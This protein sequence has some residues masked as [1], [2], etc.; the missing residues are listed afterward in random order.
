MPDRPKL[1][2]HSNS[3]WASTGYGNQTSLFAPLLN[4]HY[5]VAISAFYGLAGARL[6]WNDIP[7]LPGMEP[8]YGNEW[9]VEHARHWFDDKN[10][11]GGL[12][13]TLMD[14]W[15]LQADMA[16]QLNMACW[17]P[18]D[19]EP[20][21]PPVV[22]FFVESGAIPIAMSRFG[23]RMLGRLDPLYVPHGIDTAVLRP[24]P[25][26]ETREELGEG[27]AG[28]VFLIGMVAANKGRPSRKGFQ[29]A[30]Q[31]FREF[32]GRHDDARL[33]LHTV[34]TPLHGQGEDLAALIQAL[35]LPQHAVIFTDQYAAMLNP[36]PLPVMAKIYSAMDVL[37]NPAF[38]EGFGIP[39]L[40][41]QACGVP[42]VVTNF[43]AMQ[44]TCGAGWKVGCRPQWTGQNSWMAQPDVGE[45]VEALEDCYT[46]S[47]ARR[48]DMSQGARLHALAYDVDTVFEEFWLP[49]LRVIEQR[50]ALQEP[51]MI[52]P[53]KLEA[54]A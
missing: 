44:E 29:Q 1:I 47:A 24:H 34:G 36:L 41:A 35:E 26:L 5:D 43:S 15:V 54:A 17:V 45:I 38:G 22:E 33:Y 18:V 4:D 9:L 51:V 27:F 42:A 49:A 13:V 14:V 8:L 37:L 20:A 6:R 19:H 23:E 11:R 40:E 28:D 25:K 31:A 21:P 32:Y 50:F 46:M 52:Q 53:R 3:P 2:W 10:P 48:E 16:K 7:V 39:V 12:V 30:L